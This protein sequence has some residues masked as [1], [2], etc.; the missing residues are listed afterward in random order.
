MR[1]VYRFSAHS[2]KAEALYPTFIDRVPK[3]T[4]RRIGE[5]VI[6]T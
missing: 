4:I 5:T 3:I 6:E 2:F 1:L